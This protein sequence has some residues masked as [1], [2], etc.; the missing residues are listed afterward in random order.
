[1]PED[2]RGKLRLLTLYLLS[3]SPKHGYSL[4]KELE[5]I[6]GRVPS[7]GTIYPLLKDLLDSGLVEVQVRRKEG[8]VIKTYHI[9]EGGRKFLNERREELERVLKLVRS[10]MK[11]REVGGEELLSALRELG[12]ALADLSEVELEKV[13]DILSKCAS[14]IMRILREVRRGE[15]SE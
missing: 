4:M 7:P 9:T 14:E 15:G 10:F 8:K 1:M 6:I 12:K 2:I 11:F 5:G 3:R 13:R